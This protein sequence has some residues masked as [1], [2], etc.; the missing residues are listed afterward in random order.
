VIL[1]SEVGLWT[2]ILVSEVGLWTVSG[3]SMAAACGQ[4][5]GQAG[6]PV[7][8]TSLAEAHYKCQQAKVMETGQD[9]DR[10]EGLPTK[11]ISRYKSQPMEDRGRPVPD[12]GRNEGRPR[13]D[14]RSDKS[15]PIHQQR[16]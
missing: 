1:V 14:G 6:T 16:M 13:K 9:E 3:F 5:F 10:N 8:R 12:V 15:Y 2:V 7:K 4:N 11:D